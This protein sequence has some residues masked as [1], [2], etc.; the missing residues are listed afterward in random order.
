MLVNFLIGFLGVMLF[1]FIFWE[2]LNEDYSTDVIFQT[3]TSILIGISLGL[4]ASRLFLPQW[5]FWTSV[6]GSF[7]GT[8]PMIIKYKLRFY[9]TLEALILA[10]TP[11]VSLMF[12]KDS[13]V[14]SSLYSFLAFVV[15]LVLIFLSYWFD[16]NY[17]SFPWYKSGKI[18]FAGLS[19]SILFF[20]IRTVIAI[21]GL[22]MIS[23]VGRIDA[24]ISGIL[25]LICIGLLINLGRIK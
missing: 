22:T 14:N 2:R 4:I 5:F 10:S 21:L 3:A 8:I 15:S 11:F 7:L 20:S 6:L 18:G 17:K 13:I 16:F 23:F 24:L 25:V 19:A 9:E 12:F 1:L